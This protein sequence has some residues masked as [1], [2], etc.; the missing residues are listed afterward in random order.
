MGSKVKKVLSIAGL[1]MGAYG[2]YS[3]LS[4]GGAFGSAASVAT[5]AGTG[6]LGAAGIASGVH[7]VGASS[8]LTGLSGAAATT[9]TSMM[10][11][12]ANPSTSPNLLSAANL[13]KVGQL[14]RVGSTIGQLK[15]Q[16]VQASA[17]AKAE[18][19]AK[20]QQMMQARYTEAE[21]RRQRLDIIEQGRIAKGDMLA[22]AVAS[23]A[24]T[25]GTSGYVGG[26]GSISSQ[27]AS[28]LSALQ[29]A[30][31]ATKA[32]LLLSRKQGSAMSDY[33]QAANMA[34]QWESLGTLGG[35]LMQ[36]SK[37]VAGGDIFSIFS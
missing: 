20:E 18:K 8:G 15:S 21:A 12:L 23:G 4:A 30:E 37:Q 11:T 2:A 29:M 5:G 14:A 27:T 3:A 32:N 31:G 7:G 33:Y 9:S 6:H 16:Q 36:N 10:S 19:Y 25:T 24:G 1:A 28:N 17:L 22:G 26:R 13:Q 35:K 34:G